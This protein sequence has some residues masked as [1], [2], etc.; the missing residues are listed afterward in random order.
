MPG[1]KKEENNNLGM[2]ECSNIPGISIC[3]VSGSYE[4]CR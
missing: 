4:R 3:M 1:K 2:G